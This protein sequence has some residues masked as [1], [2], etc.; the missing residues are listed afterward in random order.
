MR[1]VLAVVL[2]RIVRV[3]TRLR[4]GGSA[5]PG[6]VALRVA[7]NFLSTVFDTF[8]SRGE[9]PII[10]VTGSNGK[11]TTTAMI[12]AALEANGHIVFSN[13][14]GGNLPQG[15]A[16]A[17]LAS[18]SL[19][20]SLKASAIVLELDEAY[21]PK[22]VATI[23]PTHAVLLNIQVDQL[24][25]FFEPERV[26]EMV[27]QI[28]A[29]AQTIIVNDA[30]ANTRAIGNI[31]AMQSHA[32]YGFD[33]DPAAAPRGVYDAHVGIQT[34]ADRR[35]P[36]ALVTAQSARVTGIEVDG[37]TVSVHL[38]AAG[39]HY[40]L[41]AAAAIATVAVV[42]GSRHDASVSARAISDLNP[43]YGRGEEVQAFAAPLTIVMMKNHPSL[44]MNLDALQEA[45]ESL[46]MAVDEG[47]PDPS[48]IYDIDVSALDHVDVLSGT[49]AWQWETRLAY[50]EIP[51]GLVEENTSRAFAHFGVATTPSRQ[52]FR[53]AIVNY[54]QMMD[55]RR[56][57][58]YKEIEGQQ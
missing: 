8:A 48:W 54:E 52:E 16:S 9:A 38:P 21:G 24:N 31:L 26:I 50:A 47:T 18:V 49:K 15:V 25:R 30:D 46:Y 28:G 27:H 36:R 5:L 42:M 1:T 2:G 35:A 32:V 56:E 39:L 7:P 44:Q 19:R 58:G 45:P 53:T 33:V 6:W 37:E 20:G 29:S 43:V 22:L 4:G 17:V 14:S 11:S 34:R 13:P 51:V 41:D 57:L 55:L 3:L 40:A 23:K 10:V 12:V